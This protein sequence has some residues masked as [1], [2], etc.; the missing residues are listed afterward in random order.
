MTHQASETLVNAR[1]AVFDVLAERLGQEITVTPRPRLDHQSNNLYD[2]WANGERLIVKEF[3]KPDEFNDAPRREFD[4]LTRVRDLDIAPRPVL[5]LPPS[6]ACG[7]LVVYAYMPGEMWDRRQ[8]SRLELEQLAGLWLRLHA[9]PTEGLWPSRGYDLALA[10]HAPRWRQTLTDYLAWTEAHCP[11]AT[12]Q[13]QACLDLLAARAPQIEA[14][15]GMRP[16]PAFCRSDARFA[17]VIARPD[18]RLGMVDWEDCGLRD[19]A[20]DLADLLTHANQE[21]L[22]SPAGWRA[23]LDPY[24]AERT[25]IDPTLPDRLHLYLAGFPIFWLAALSRWVIRLA[26]EGGLE[27]WTLNTM[28]ANDRLRRW[29]ARA[30]AWPNEDFCTELA[31]LDGARFF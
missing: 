22:L 8:P 31:A 24:L 11:A 30:R 5:R 21:D 26:A 3:L 18:R 9:L 14:L 17:N 25:L 16:V 29:L 6:D 4:G 1:S 7:P 2:A 23:F 20:I 28:P 19:P 13:A 12:P 10:Q 27:T 15:T